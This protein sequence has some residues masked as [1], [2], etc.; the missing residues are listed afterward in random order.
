MQIISNYPINESALRTIDSILSD[1]S[2]TF[3]IKI[4]KDTPKNLLKDSKSKLCRFCGN[5]SP[6]VT[7]KKRAHTPPEFT[8][9]KKIFSAY[10]CDSCNERYFNLF[11][12]ELA[13]FLLPFSTLSGKKVKK[14]RIPKY[15]QKGEPTI[16]HKE[17]LISI[18]NINESKVKILDDNSL[19]ITLKLPTFI[20]EYIYRCLVKICL[21]LLPEKRLSNYEMTTKWLMNLNQDSDMR[22]GMLFSTYPNNFQLDD[23]S[24]THF[25]RKDAC[26]KNIPYAMFCLSYNNYTFQTYLPY[27]LKEKQNVS[28]NGFPFILPTTFDLDRNKEIPRTVHVIDLS[29]K[30]KKT[31]EIL[32]LNMRG[33]SISK[34]LKKTKR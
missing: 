21:S 3:S 25:E 20:P 13:N 32:T 9:N 4:N 23:I 7:F 17:D 10:E 15:K 19:E 26:E 29:S 16:S 24:A 8:G 1:Y 18:N 28:I 12:N 30:K 5:S 6:Q 14:N 22:P 33:D 2:T 11:E 27:S 31:N 34:D